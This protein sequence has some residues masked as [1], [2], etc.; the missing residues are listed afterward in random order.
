[1]TPDMSM[2]HAMPGYNMPH[3]ETPSK[4]PIQTQIDRQTYRKPPLSSSHDDFISDV[5]EVERWSAK[6]VKTGKRERHGTE[7]DRTYPL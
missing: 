4:I 6:S 5:L 2:P 7:T 3:D 1:M